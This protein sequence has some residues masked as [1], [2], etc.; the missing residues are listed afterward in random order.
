M[1]RNDEVSRGRAAEIASMVMRTNAAKLYGL[2]VQEHPRQAP[3][4]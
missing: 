2:G 1:I 4:P 3:E